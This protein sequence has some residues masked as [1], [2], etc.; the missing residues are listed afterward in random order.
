[1]V[2]C[3]ELGCSVNAS[4]AVDGD[5]PQY[6]ASHKED[7][8]VIVNVKRCTHP[9]CSLRALFG[10]KTRTV[11]FCEGHKLPAM[12]NLKGNKTII[13]NGNESDEETE[14]DEEIGSKRKKKEVLKIRIKRRRIS[15]KKCKTVIKSGRCGCFSF[16]P[17]E[18]KVEPFEYDFVEIDDKKY[19][20]PT[21]TIVNIYTPKG[22]EDFITFQL[23]LSIEANDGI[24]IVSRE[25]LYWHVPKFREVLEKI[26][27]KDARNA[28]KMNI[29]VRDIALMMQSF[30]DKNVINNTT[31]A[32]IVKALY[33]F[34]MG[35]KVWQIVTHNKK[36]VNLEVML[37]LE[38][39][40]LKLAI[41][42]LTRTKFNPLNVPD[43]MKFEKTTLASCFCRTGMN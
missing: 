41:Q 8:M 36:Y 4:F 21:E 24:I 7:G 16:Y 18:E 15:C 10:Y 42:C 1:M 29:N 23:G 32:S 25:F 6:C 17:S 39:H 26:A 11:E 31:S 19:F 28:V 33:L 40:D 34:D 35:D 37:L 14:S 13:I 9:D 3:K 30:G 12:V 20:K 5:R 38:K 43:L 27:S 2:K 22:K